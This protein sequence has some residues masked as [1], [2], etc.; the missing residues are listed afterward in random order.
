MGQ[1]AGGGVGDDLLD[2]GVVAVLALGLQGR[3]PGGDEHGVVAPGG[4]QLVL[5]GRDRAGVELRCPAFLGHGFDVSLRCRSS[6]GVVVVG[7]PRGPVPKVPS[8]A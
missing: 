3:E 5:P 8:E 4:E 1:G 2:D 7:L 6:V